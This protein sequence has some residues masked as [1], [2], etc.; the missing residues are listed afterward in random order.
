M[1]LADQNINTLGSTSVTGFENLYIDLRAKEQR[2]YSDEEVLKLP[3]VNTDHIHKAEWTIR[4]ESYQKLIRYLSKKKKFLRILELGCGNGWL[5]NSLATGLSS[6]VTGIDINAVEIEQ[7]H[8]VFGSQKN[9]N[10][11]YTSLPSDLF[12]NEKF[13][14]IIFAA[15]IQYFSSLTTII[16]IAKQYLNKAGEIH[17]LDTC[18]YKKDSLVEAK[19]RSKD[20]FKKMEFENMEFFYFHHSIDEVQRFDPD[21]LYNPHSML[22]KISKK[23]PFYWFRIKI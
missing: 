15:S 22:N 8:R 6:K 17:I 14:I 1:S 3:L 16:N 9:L 5:S 21:I 4:K 10:F 7:A 13:D 12:K 23:N 2:I 20:Y 18:F 11:F 19:G